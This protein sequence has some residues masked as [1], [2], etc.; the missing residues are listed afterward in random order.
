MQ[1]R[2][3]AL[4]VFVS[5]PLATGMSAT[6]GM[7]Q[8]THK[9][10][11]WY[12]ACSDQGNTKICNVQYQA[13]ASTGQVITSINLAEITGETERKVFQI[14]VPTGRM[15]PPGLK[16]KIGEKEE[17]TIPYSFCTPRICAA[18]LPLKDDLVADLKSGG[19]INIKSVNWQGKENPI[20]L[21]LSGFAEAYDG[22]AIARD[23]LAA[24]QQK[25]EE[26]LQQKSSDILKKLQEAQ[27]KARSGDASGSD[28]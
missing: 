5:I 2:H 21:T 15:V 25:L 16:V 3:V 6:A 9:S 12:K 8:E 23:E 19:T 22:E 7:A 13:V 24:R 10:S 27:E 18:E 20:E 4:S 17:R 26:E 14:T 28:N 1:I 11:G